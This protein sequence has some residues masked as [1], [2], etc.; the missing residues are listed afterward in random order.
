[1]FPARFE[2][3]EQPKPS[4]PNRPI[5]VWDLVLQNPTGGGGEHSDP[6]KSCSVH[7]SH[8]IRTAGCFLHT[9]Q[10]SY[11]TQRT[12]SIHSALNK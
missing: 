9:V 11:E 6:H 3:V 5:N 7:Y 8:A 10:V 1:M 2:S 4:S 12:A